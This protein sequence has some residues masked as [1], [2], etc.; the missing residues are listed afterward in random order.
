VARTLRDIPA[1]ASC[2]RIVHK[3]RRLDKNQFHT[4]PTSGLI[5][6]NALISNWFLHLTVARR[7]YD[8]VSG[9]LA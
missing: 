9:P 2:N 8:E 4:S 5:L 7:V 3:S 1:P 6:R